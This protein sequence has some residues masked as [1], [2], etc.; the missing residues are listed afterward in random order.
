MT[1]AQIVRLL[2][3]G[4]QTHGSMTGQ[5]ERDVL[6]ARLFGLTAVVQSGLLVRS[7]PAAALASYEEVLAQLL[8]LGETKSWLRESAWWT[9]GRAVD[10]LRA[11]DVA[12][13]DAAFQATV[14]AVF[15]ADKAW[16]PEKVA[17]ALKLQKAYPSHD[18]QKTLAPTFR[19]APLLHTANYAALARIMKVRFLFSQSVCAP[20]RV[21][22]LVWR[23]GQRGVCSCHVMPQDLLVGDDDEDEGTTK[24]KNGSWKPQVHF[25]WDLLLDE[26]LSSAHDGSSA[27]ASFPEFFRILV[28]G[29]CCLWFFPPPLA[30]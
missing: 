25:V 17:L 11:A 3:D 18:W 4:T 1:C 12:W 5:E 13:Q 27:H 6:F 21:V 2:A 26:V 14:Q 15:V 10:A 20:P 16:S 24:G 19:H 8:A 7:T 23:E 22:W 30:F 29:A 9:I 28:D